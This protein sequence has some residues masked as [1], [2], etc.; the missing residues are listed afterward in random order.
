MDNEIR[1]MEDVDSVV[2]RIVKDVVSD[3]VLI[4]LLRKFNNWRERWLGLKIYLLA[5]T[6]LYGIDFF[7]LQYFLIE[8]MSFYE[9]QKETGIDL[10][11]CKYFEPNWRNRVKN[12]LEGTHLDPWNYCNY[13][14]KKIPTT[15]NGTS[16]DFCVFLRKSNRKA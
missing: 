16:K 7:S 4:D 1:K 14:G 3:E 5:K 9:I 12:M 8:E 2:E 6:K 15:C 13:E 11:F 10:G